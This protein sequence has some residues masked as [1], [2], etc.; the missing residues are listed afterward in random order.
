MYR[1]LL[2]PH[3]HTRGIW[4]MELTSRS[5]DE[6][7]EA[8]FEEPQT[9]PDLVA[10]LSVS[11]STVDR[12]L[13]D[14][15]A[16]GR[17]ESVGSSY[18]LTET[19][20]LMVQE[21][22]VYRS[23]MA[24]LEDARPVL[25]NVSPGSVEMEFLRGAT[26]ETADPCAP[27]NVFETISTII[28]AAS[29]LYGTV[30]TVGPTVFDDLSEAVE[31][32]GL[33]CELI[34]DETLYDSFTESERELIHEVIKADGGRLLTRSLSDS[35]SIWIADG[36]QGTHA[37]LVV[38]TIGGPCGIIHNDDPNAVAWARDQYRE[39]RASATVVWDYR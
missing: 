15:E 16:N 22:Q 6:I 36:E 2:L 39:R 13:A 27:W 35:Y 14:L 10:A 4:L 8:L 18:R 31:H 32:G 23:H 7:L 17:V 3:K 26:V 37:G 25:E 33:T 19:G 21:R 5:K 28:N 1:Q 20:R 11:R 30:P 34:I 12:R 38:Y 24:T 9:K 29:S